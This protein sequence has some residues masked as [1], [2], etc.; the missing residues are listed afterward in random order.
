MLQ[1]HIGLCHRNSLFSECLGAAINSSGLVRCS[2]F[3]PE[4]LTA[5][6]D[7]LGKVVTIELILLDVSLN[8]ELADR[9]AREIHRFHPDC[10][11]LLMVAAPAI[12]R[13]LDMAKFGGQ[14]CLYEEAPLAIVRTA[15]ETVLAGRPFCSPEL[16]NALMA[17]MGQVDRNSTWSKHLDDVQLTARERE[18]LELIAWENLGNKQ[19]ARRLSV[20]LYTV[21][22]H[23]HN[24]IEKLGVADRHEAVQFAKKRKLLLNDRTDSNDPVIVKRPR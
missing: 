7:S 3:S 17:Q 11:L 22:N 10:K 20:S 21:K 19:I 2:V 12:D 5:S 6:I 18:V 14:G 4:I 8:D 24:I 16:A 9:V 15:I 13:M 23:V 1:P